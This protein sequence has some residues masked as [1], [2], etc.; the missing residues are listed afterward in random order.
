[1]NSGWSQKLLISFKFCKSPLAPPWKPRPEAPPWFAFA[2]SRKALH[3]TAHL[4]PLSAGVRA[5]HPLSCHEP[6]REQ[7]H[8]SSSQVLAQTP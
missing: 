4:Q 6:G 1:M 7:E 5:R 3:I 2:V 8:G